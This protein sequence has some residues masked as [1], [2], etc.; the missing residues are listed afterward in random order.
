MTIADTQSVP[1]D[2][3]SWGC[4]EDESVNFALG[5]GWHLAAIF[6]KDLCD[7]SHCDVPGGYLFPTHDEKA[8]L[9][10]VAGAL[11][12][13]TSI[14]DEEVV[15]GCGNGFIDVGEACDGSDLGGASCT[16]LGFPGGTLACRADCTFET[17][18]CLFCHEGVREPD[19]GE[20]CDDLDFGGATCADYGFEMGD[21]ICNSCVTIDTSNCSG[22][23]STFPPGSYKDCGFDFEDPDNPAAC[24]GGTCTGAD[25]TCA[26]GPCKPTNPNDYTSALDP[27]NTQGGEFHPDGNFRSANGTLFDRQRD[28][29]D[30][31]MVCI[32]EDGWGVCTRCSG[33]AGEHTTL[34]GCPCSSDDECESASQPGLGCFGEDYGGGIGFCWDAQ[35]GPPAWQCPEG[36]CGQS[37]Y[38]DLDDPDDD[39]MFC[40]HY[41]ISGQPA[42][43]QP[44][45]ACNDILS[46]VCASN[47]P[48]LICGEDALGCTEVECCVAECE[49][50]THC[51]EA[52]GWPPNFTCEGP[53]QSNLRCVYT[54]P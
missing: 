6:N 17:T 43:C 11:T 18:P 3:T 54:P 12:Q 30:V 1:D 41:S 14:P 40:E 26:G 50:D 39:A 53:D 35:D 44:W 51:T 13:V 52:L 45:A 49:D 10:A 21:L 16:S 29:N 5:P 2:C 4:L 37:L 46:R 24:S 28:E 23:M 15:C 34:L 32:D 47:G 19:K 38:Y 9:N 25:G 7:T 48:G 22:G 8:F 27:L 31:H 33:F 20:V 42:R 36:I